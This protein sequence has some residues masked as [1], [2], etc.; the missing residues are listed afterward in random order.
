MLNLTTTKINLLLFIFSIELSAIPLKPNEYLLFALEKLKRSYPDHI[1]TFTSECVTWKDGSSMVLENSN[2][3]K[4]IEQRRDNPSLTDQLEQPLYEEGC[5]S[6]EPENDSGRIR[7]EPFFLKMYGNTPKEVEQQLEEIDWM[8]AIFGQGTYKLKVTK[9]NNVHE[10]IRC[11]SRELETLVLANPEA[12][13]FLKEP[14][15]TYCWRTI[16]RTGRL[17]PH[18]FGMAFDINVALS[19]YWQWDLARN[20]QEISEDT[21]LK[22]QNTIPWEIVAIFEKYGFIWGGKWYHYDTMHFEYRPELIIDKE[23]QA[24]V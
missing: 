10:K 4:S 5:P 15:G 19:H 3:Q 13:I 23:E 11:I 7:Y 21:L 9:I 18:S 16:A 2:P 1:E 17:S 8:P 14:G 20:N 12:A 24:I 22:Y 6:R